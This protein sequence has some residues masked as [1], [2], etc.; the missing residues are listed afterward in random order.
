MRAIVVSFI[1]AIGLSGC[2]MVERTPLT[3]AVTALRDGNYEDF[4][5]A[6]AEAQAALNTA[7]QHGMDHCKFTALDIQKHGEAAL[8][9]RLDHPELFKLFEEAR[10]VYAVNVAGKLN[11]ATKEASELV[12]SFQ[13]PDSDYSLCP[14]KGG[15]PTVSYQ[16]GPPGEGARRAVLRN[17]VDKLKDGHDDTQ[18]DAA[19]T[20]AVAELENF[21]LSAVWPAE[22]TLDDEEVPTF[23]PVENNVGETRR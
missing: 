3:H 7:W 22:L 21:G 18:F 11:A 20:N 15:P 10:F 2:G 6:K 5:M 12:Q 9:N 8:V 17:W 1:L 14:D 23:H 19:M 16:D 13:Q 4:V